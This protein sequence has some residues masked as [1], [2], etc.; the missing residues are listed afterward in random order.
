MSV[1]MEERLGR[2]T[3]TLIEPI[4]VLREANDRMERALGIK[5][6]RPNLELVHDAEA[7]EGDDA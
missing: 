7:K 2:A 5:P 1:T 3:D 6:P 4:E